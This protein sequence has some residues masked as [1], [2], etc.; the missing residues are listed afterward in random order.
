MGK[1]SWF[2]KQWSRYDL[3]ATKLQKFVS[4]IGS[5][6]M[7]ATA[8]ALGAEFLLLALLL[9]G[10]GGLMIVA[11]I[12]DK[13]G[14]QAR[15]LEANFDQQS[16]DLWWNQVNVLAILY[17]NY[18]E[19]EYDDRDKILLDFLK[20]LNIPESHYKPLFDAL[21]RRVNQ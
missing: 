21:D 13:V 10:F 19:M 3:T 7:I 14:F 20:K 12:L 16:R 4:M 6:S 5:A 11:V 15:A 18:A 1:V 17:N 8:I 9:L 2:G